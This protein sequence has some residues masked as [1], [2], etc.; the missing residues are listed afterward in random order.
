MSAFRSCLWFNGNALEAVELYKR[1]FKEVEIEQVEKYGK[2]GH[3]IHGQAE[4][5]V[6]TIAFNMKGQS[7]L[8]LNGGANFKFNPSFSNFIYCRS[9]SEMDQIWTELAKDGN[10]RMEMGEYPW[11]KK[12]GWIADRFGVEWQVIFSETQNEI[13]PSLLFVDE[14][15]GKGLQALNFYTQHF[16]NSKILSKAMDPSNKI[17]MHAQVEL[18]GQKINLMEG[19]GKHGH[20]FNEAYSLI[21]SCATQEEID[22][23]WKGLTNGG[24]PGPCGWLKDPF[25]V[26]WQVVP[27]HLSSW[28]RS[29]N[30]QQKERFMSE[31]MKMSKLDIATLQ[32]TLK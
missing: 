15:Y 9:T 27:A 28:L 2:A 26:S 4:G 1:I 19:E 25:G 3:D 23:H 20:V 30:A 10:V 32:A 7:F 13:V 24:S 14:L 6:M 21:I 17:V 29:A 31:M 22:Y 5:S 8:A 16:K 11:S 12:Y 18:S